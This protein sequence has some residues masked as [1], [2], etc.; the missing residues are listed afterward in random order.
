MTTAIAPAAKT[1]AR[2]EPVSEPWSELIHRACRRLPPLWPLKKFV[3]VNPFLGH[4]DE[5]FLEAAARLRRIAHGEIMLPAARY[6]EL[7]DAGK[8]SEADLA[9]AV[10]HGAATIPQPWAR[11]I[12]ALSLADL[13]LQLQA[14]I[15]APGPRRVLSFADFIDDRRG[16]HRL[17][18][19]VDEISKWCSVYFDEGQSSWRMPWRDRP[20]FEAW[21]EAARHDRN[22]ALNGWTEFSATVNQ[23]GA[24]PYAEI[25]GA[26]AA[27]GVPAG[28]V[29]DFLHRQL[30]SLPGW[31]AY[32][33]YK[34]RENGMHGRPDRT[35]VD[36]LAIRLAYDRALFAQFGADTADAWTERLQHAQL[37]EP[38]LDLLPRYL[39]HLVW[40]S[41]HAR[42]VAGKIMRS[43]ARAQAKESSTKRKTLQAIFCIDVR[44]EVFRRAL[45]AQSEEV[46]TLGFAGFFGVAVEFIRLGER[47]GA[48]QCP[49]LLTPQFKVREQL[50][51]DGK[52]ETDV[53]HRLRLRKRI[54][55]AWNAFKTS[56]I[57]CFSFVE[58]SGLAFG[59]KLAR[60]SWGLPTAVDQARPTCCRVEISVPESG[61]AHGQGIP[62]D[63][64]VK[65]AEGALRNMSLTANF[66]RVVLI[67]GHGSETR[68]NPYASGL[69]CGACGGHAGDVNARVA[70]SILNASAVR[71]ALKPRGIDIPDDTIFLA[72]L[73]NTTTDEVTIFDENATTHA[74]ADDIVR[75]EAWLASAAHLARRERAPALGL[76]PDASKIDA[77]V[78]ARSRDWAQVRPEWGLAGNAAFIVAPRDRTAGESF[79]GRTFLHNY[80]PERDPTGAV[81]E[82]IMIAPMV[83]T[84]WIN[85]QY[86][87]STVNNR[88]F[89]SGNKTIHN[90]VGT[91][92]VWQGNGG[93][94]QVGLPL[95]SLHDGVEWRHEPLRLHVFIE[96]ST[97]AIDRVLEKHASIR[98][99]VA[100][101][102]LHLFALGDEG[103][104]CSRHVRPGLWR[105]FSAGPGD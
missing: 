70:A 89:G 85:L 55:Y 44:S 30:A 88:L 83:V 101:G 49:V 97:A 33:Q 84:N 53:V 103:R 75:I 18:L 15:E 105:R 46:D 35:L 16:S 76:D 60:D 61:S 23:L 43:S 62:V 36:L 10:L 25:E 4:S 13:K 50:D 68:N 17:A 66:A 38:Q 22:P 79:G 57:S 100:N 9:E 1:V 47:H 21:R 81:L 6:L 64:Q 92:G 87:A 98:E 93:D 41:A 2:P 96:A 7:I 95:Q 99:L 31:S 42:T 26:L 67:C 24:D 52:P 32:A 34:V 72:A 8:M 90:V 74:R 45:E 91:L 102:W 63:E 54:G 71:L 48:A 69:D 58:T 12:A 80:A 51:R 82:L 65:L 78:I 14:A 39:A 28:F 5:H 104:T 40:E 27:L 19:L 77:Q 20:L 86:F 3:A 29:E 94:L 73:H 59:W 37:F 11:E 56:A